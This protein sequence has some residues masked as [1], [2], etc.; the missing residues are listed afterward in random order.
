MAAPAV[1]FVT[2]TR[3]RAG[4]WKTRLNLAADGARPWVHFTSL[5]SNTPEGRALAERRAAEKQA[6]ADE[7]EMVGADFGLGPRRPRVQQAPVAPTVQTP[8]GRTVSSWFHSYYD[9]C[10]AG[11][12]GRKNG[13]RAQVSAADRRRRFERWIEPVIGSLVMAAVTPDDLRRVVKRIDAAIRER[14][15]D[16]ES[17]T[18]EQREKR[19]GKALGIS[20]KF[21]KHLW[22]ELTSAFREAATSKHDELRVRADVPT[23]LVQPPT[24]GSSRESAALFP[25]EVV[26]L[27]S[28]PAEKVPTYRRALYGVAAYTGLRVGELRGLMP[29]DVDLEHDAIVVRRQ[30]RGGGKGTGRTKTRAGRRSVPIEPALRP[31]LEVLVE[32][33]PEGKPLL[34]V[35]P[36][37]DCAELVRKDLIAVGCDREELFADDAERGPFV[38]HG[39]RHTC[40][41]HWAVAG[42]SM[43]WMLAAAGHT[44]VAMT[45]RYVD[46]A[47]VLRGRFGE[48]HPPIPAS[49]LDEL[50]L[51]GLS[52]IG[53]VA[54][55]VM[56]RGTSAIPTGIEVA[57]KRNDAESDGDSRCEGAEEAP[58]KCAKL[59][60]AA[61]VGQRLRLVR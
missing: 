31:L 12:V 28:S 50:E 13:G 22:G 18:A 33:C 55:N 44:N 16:Y 2:A 47:A 30:N 7:N 45:M 36:P 32:I 14:V 34:R 53:G 41:T 49:L 11:T 19:S 3:R 24:S 4:H 10:E 57:V 1:F 29:D 39:L 37:E 59:R 52:R 17:T 51:S 54:K 20:A 5:N 38:F 23:A 61:H 43:P 15:V 25:S 42:K 56:I 8:A 60:P 35:P 46:S 40:L 48:P 9:H 26:A 58:A 6:E 27:L 21:G